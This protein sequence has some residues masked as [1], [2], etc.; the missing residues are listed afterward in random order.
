MLSLLVLDSSSAAESSQ[1]PPPRLTRYNS[2]RLQH[3]LLYTSLRLKS[4]PSTSSG[5]VRRPFSLKMHPAY[6][7]PVLSRL[8]SAL[9]LM[10]LPAF[11]LTCP[12]PASVSASCTPP[13]PI[14]ALVNCHC[15]PLV[16]PPAAPPAPAPDCPC[17]GKCPT[18]PLLTMVSCF[19]TRVLCSNPLSWSLRAASIDGVLG[20]APSTSALDRVSFRTPGRCLTRTIVL[21]YL[22]SAA[23]AS[24]YPLDTGRVDTYFWP[25][26]LA[27][28]TSAQFL[29]IGWVACYC[30]R[31]LVGI[32][33]Y[34]YLCRVL[35]RRA[36]SKPL[37]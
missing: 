15:S 11:T 22:C 14:Y 24:V 7:T 17:P 37:E 6:Q 28:I 25:T 13:G 9:P 34:I 1:F 19:Q 5:S 33:V 30:P 21:L 2:P 31:I 8:V 29:G 4:G 27:C 26:W 20:S 12:A 16:P 35:S 36:T 10:H 23:D 18:K 32:N 3:A